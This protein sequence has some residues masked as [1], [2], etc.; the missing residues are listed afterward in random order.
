MSHFGAEFALAEIRQSSLVSSHC[1][2]HILWE[3]EL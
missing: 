3:Q 2:L 1:V